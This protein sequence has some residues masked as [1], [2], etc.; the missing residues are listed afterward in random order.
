MAFYRLRLLL[1]VLIGISLMNCRFLVNH[2]SFYPDRHDLLPTNR[3]PAGVEERFIETEDKQRLQCYW[4]PS[5]GSKDLLIYFHGNA[6]NIGHRLPDLQTL[7]DMKLNVLGVGYRG[8]GRSTGKVSEQGIYADGRA[9]LQYATAT[10][11]FDSAHIILFGRS[12]GSTVAVDVGQH[13][14][15]KAVILV[16]PMTSGKAVGKIH[17]GPLARLAGNAFDNSSKIGHIRSPLLIVHGTDDEVIPFSMGQT[18]Y[19]RAPQPKRFV[20]IQGAGHNDIGLSPTGAYWI[21]L[22]EYILGLS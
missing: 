2:F 22:R 1:W 4:I 6:G 8:Y 20:P 3:L 10:L 7:A 21:A 12:I 16:T 13:K 18:L 15:L 19:E 5:P 11:G 14:A 9:A 17:F